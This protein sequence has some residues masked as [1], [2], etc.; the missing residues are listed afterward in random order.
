MSTTPLYRTAALNATQVKW[1]GDIV[2][3]RPIAF[4]VLTYLATLFAVVVVAFLIWGTYT[5]RVPVS[6]QLVPDLGLVKVYVP[7]PGIVL[8]KRVMEGQA[9]TRGDILYAL[10]SERQS[11][12][13][14]NIQEAISAQV[15]TRQQ[16]LRDERDKTQML[17]RDERDAMGKKNIGLQAELEKLDSQLEGQKNRVK[18]AEETVARYQSLLSQDY[19]SKEQWQQKQEEFLDQRNRLQT[20]ERERMSVNRELSALQSDLASLAN[21]QQNQLAQ[22]DR[23]ITSTVQ[24]LTESEAKRRLIITAPESGIATVVTAELG[25]T[26]DMNRPLVSIVPTGAGMEAH[27]YAPSKAI[28]FIKTGD[29]VLIRY[30]AYP[31]QK[32]GQ[33]KG[34]VVAISKAAISSSELGSMSG[35]SNGGSP[36]NSEPMYRISVKLANQTVRAYGRDLPLHAGM[37]L[38]ADILQD[39]RRLYEWVLEPLYSLTGKL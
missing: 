35:S 1:L 23:G 38:D 10:S 37:V 14:G 17:Q 20:Q 15:E 34:T 5:K 26:V 28:G 22:I 8:Q 4:S 18:L 36:G 13:L 7:Q 11:S 19:I 39:T 25:Q 24:E 29:S 2:L 12:T 21:R 31:Y 33:A 30:Q 6:G 27:L 16:S 32:F 3:A 9:V